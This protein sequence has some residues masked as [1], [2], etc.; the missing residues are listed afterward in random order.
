MNSLKLR[1][2]QNKFLYKIA[3]LIFNLISYFTNRRYIKGKRNSI[4]IHSN[5]MYKKL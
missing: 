1:I 3:V 5:V 4:D 2:I